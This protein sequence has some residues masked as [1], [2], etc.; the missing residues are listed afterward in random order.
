MI[1]VHEQVGGEY[2]VIPHE[3]ILE[4]LAPRIERGLGK[5]L[6]RD[7]TV[8]EVHEGIDACHLTQ[9]PP[10]MLL[11]QSWVHQRV[12]RRFIL[13]SVYNSRLAV[14]IMWIAEC[15]T[16]LSEETLTVFLCMRVITGITVAH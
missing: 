6:I 8:E 9:C 12:G 4:V 7:A 2:V 13:T 10:R 11:A 1:G 16:C 14:C 5:V 15:E 3:A